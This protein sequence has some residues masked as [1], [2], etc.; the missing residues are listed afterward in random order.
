[1]WIRRKKGWERP[2]NEVMSESLYA[3]R[4]QIVKSI[5]ALGAST[6]APLSA[7]GLEVREGDSALVPPLDE[8]FVSP[9]ND[10]FPVPRNN[11]YV[12]PERPLTDATSATR[13]N[14]FY[15]FTVAKDRVWQLV[16]DFEIE[17]WT[18]EIAGLAGNTGIFDVED[19]MRRFSMEERIYR[20]RCVERWA[21][22]VPWTG[23]PLADLVAFA[24]PM[25]GARYVAMI[26]ENRPE[27]MPGVAA[28]GY[29]WP[30]FEA[31]TIEEA[32]NELA[33]MATGIFGQAMPRQNGAPLRLI[34]PWKYGYKN[35][36]SIIRVEFTAEQPGT[37]WNTINANEYGF[38][39]NVNPNRP[40]PRWSQ[41]EEW[42][43][44]GRDPIPTMLYNGYEEYVGHLYDGSED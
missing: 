31:L 38:Y 30:Y 20:F 6:I 10:F 36:K 3:S 34:V 21:M 28:T 14:N 9:Y 32:T 2:E 19:L 12:V 18:V 15:E 25:A 13:Y 35:T 37:F 17:P 1:M 42:L 39:S 33:M 7:C 11:A 27:Q 26:S 41:A 43:I 16:G 44:P 4:R 40:H 29:P 8:D 23:F 24:E 5:A 22:T